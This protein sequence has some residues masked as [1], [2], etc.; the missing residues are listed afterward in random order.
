MKFIFL[1]LWNFTN[2]HFAEAF[3]KEHAQSTDVFC[4]QET[5]EKSKWFLI[6]ILK[7][8]KS[9]SDYKYISDEDAF[10]LATYI[11]DRVDVVSVRTLLMDVHLTGFAQQFQLRVRGED[12]HVCNVHGAS[13]PG[14]KLDNDAR[15]AQSGGI[16]HAFEGFKGKKIIGGDFNLELNIQ[17]IKMFEEK[18]YQNLIRDYGVSTTRNKYVS[19]RYPDN[20]QYYSDYVFVDKEIIVKDFTVPDIEASDH[21]PLI[22]TI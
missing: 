15:I 12:I 7:N 4:F 19:D 20:K 1:N 10:P 18:G 17:S 14:D 21:L 6:D 16:I 11:K 8:F 13:K 3:I 5:Y 9:Y 22:L 2:R